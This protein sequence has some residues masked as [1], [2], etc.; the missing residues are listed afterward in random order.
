M[1]GVTLVNGPSSEAAHSNG[2]GE[3][4]GEQGTSRRTSEGDVDLAEM[5]L[6]PED[7]ELVCLSELKGFLL[8]ESNKALA[9]GENSYASMIM[10][11]K[12]VMISVG[13]EMQQDKV[14]G[15]AL[16]APGAV[17]APVGGGDEGHADGKAK[18]A[19]PATTLEL[20]RA[21]IQSSNGDFALHLQTRNQARIF[22]VTRLPACLPT[23]PSFPPWADISLSA[24]RALSLCVFVRVYPP[25]SS[26]GLACA[27]ALLCAPPLP[28]AHPPF[29]VPFSRPCAGCNE[30]SRAALASGASTAVKSQTIS[31]ELF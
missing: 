3:R 2:G 25:H 20:E 10:M 15:G 11:L 28:P 26:S 29:S 13:S 1:G 17:Q 8:R 5:Q 21:G 9:G 31:L 16:P 22:S 18:T 7:F 30:G 23:F 14:G 12:W 6:S 4:S 27:R 24:G 19:S